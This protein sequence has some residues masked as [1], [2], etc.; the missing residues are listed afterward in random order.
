VSAGRRARLSRWTTIGAAAAL[1]VTA[2]L[3]AGAASAQP[4]A[5][6]S[7][8]DAVLFLYNQGKDLLEA[9]KVREACAAFEEARGLDPR[10]INLLM[11]LGDCYE[12][13]GRARSA[14]RAYRDAAAA[15]AATRDAR[16][17][18]ATERAQALEPRLSRLTLLLPPSSDA[19]GLTVARDGAAVPRAELG[20]AMPV[21]PGVTT[22]EARAPGKVG[23][24]LRQEVGGD[25]ARV[26]VTI[27][28]LADAAP[29]APPTPRADEGSAG[30]RRI[31]AVVSG[32][33]GVLG[34]GAGAAF[35]VKALAR[36][37][38]SNAGRCDAQS[39][40]DDAGF[41]LRTEARQAGNVS[42]AM[43]AGGVAALGAGAALFFTARR[44]PGA[45]IKVFGAAAKGSGGLDLQGSF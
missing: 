11:R 17:V 25:G 23:W 40:C 27:P 16:A 10:A 31:L 42:T 6:A 32:A 1:S 26:V 2:C 45:K 9:G 24:T 29:A 33:V 18:A 5:G 41:A 12:R 36:N 21:D 39:F 19:P 35:G 44:A 15:A 13:L 28:R 4:P 43:F 37:R 34:I 30:A 8:R 14:Q 3:A 22:I 20:A 7:S 38:D